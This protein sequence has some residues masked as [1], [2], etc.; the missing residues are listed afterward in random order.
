MTTEILFSNNTLNSFFNLPYYQFSTTENFLEAHYE[1]HFAGFFF[2]KIPAIRKLK[3]QVVAGSHL[4]YTESNKEYLEVT[5]GIENIFK[6]ARVDW[7]L[8][9]P[10]GGGNEHSVRLRIGF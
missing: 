10:N 1:H 3:W 2:Q 9:M 4:L 7:A 6:I 5:A 8:S